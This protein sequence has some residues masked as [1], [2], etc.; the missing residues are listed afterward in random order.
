MNY[1][2]PTTRTR[3]CRG[4]TIVELLVT[5]GVIGVL[6]AISAPALFR[7]RTGAGMVQSLANL[8]DLSL[9]FALYSTANQQRYPFP[10]LFT[11]SPTALQQYGPIPWNPAGSLTDPQAAVLVFSPIWS[12]D[13]NWSGVMHDVAPWPEH[14]RQWLSPGRLDSA[15]AEQSVYSVRVSY[16]YSNSFLASPRVWSGAPG[17][18][19]SEI[20]PTR[21]SDTAFPSQKVLMFDADRSYLRQAPTPAD[22]RP[23]L[24][25]DG[26][27]IARLDSDAAPGVPNPLNANSQS[28]YHNT[29]GGV[30]GRDF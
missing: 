30:L 2:T 11:S 7:V 8:H 25:A 20:G 3:P 29:P 23:L 1:S 26:A 28:R 13:R 5:I 22:P 27:A 18:A 24:F 19:L 9:S 10:P 14:Y 17:V 15:E 4:F 12:M 6:I 21:Q 16:H